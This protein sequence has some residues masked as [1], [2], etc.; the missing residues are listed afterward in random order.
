MF[1]QGSGRLERQD[2]QTHLTPTHCHKSQVPVVSGAGPEVYVNA[3][4]LGRPSRACDLRRRSELPKKLHG[5]YSFS[6]SAGEFL[7]PVCM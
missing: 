1:L 2:P 5:P 3:N 6:A 7:R 4:R